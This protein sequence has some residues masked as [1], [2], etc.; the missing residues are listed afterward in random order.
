M[1]TR[2][3]NVPRIRRTVRGFIRKKPLVRDAVL[4]MSMRGWS[5][6]WSCCSRTKKVTRSRTWPCR[7]RATATLCRSVNVRGSNARMP[8]RI[9][10]PFAIL[11]I[12]NPD[13]VSCF[14]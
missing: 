10:F 13:T 8:R 1:V 3:A 4:E 7:M 2:M 6:S 14:G 5:P 11:P 9:L 12:T